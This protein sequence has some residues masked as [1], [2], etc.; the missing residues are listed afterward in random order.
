M[1]IVAHVAIYESG[2]MP[3][4]TTPETYTKK[5]DEWPADAIGLNCSV[6]PKATLE[7]LEFM[8]RY[9]HKPMSAM[10][11]AGLPSPL[12]VRQPCL[13]SPQYMSHHARHFCSPA[14]MILL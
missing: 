11:N 9:S 8:K 1:V 10:P 4:G 2:N 12:K 5:L 6:R 14:A 3:D 13:C 7:T